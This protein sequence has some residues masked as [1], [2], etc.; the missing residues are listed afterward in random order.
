MKVEPADRMERMELGRE[1]RVN[2]RTAFGIALR[3]QDARG[4][5][6]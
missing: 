5:M 2:G 4:L 1:E 3:G 6:E